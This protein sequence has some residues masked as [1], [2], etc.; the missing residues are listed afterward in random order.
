MNE[1][2]NDLS[3]L[4]YSIASTFTQDKTLIKDLYQQGVIGALNACK[5]YRSECNAKFSTYARM[6]IYGEIYRYI[7]CNKT[8]MI[9][10][11]IAR[12]YFNILKAYDILTQE[13][14]KEPSIKEISEY[15]NID[16]FIINNIIE[17]MRNPLSINYEYEDDNNLENYIKFN[18]NNNMELNELLDSL[19]EEERELIIHRYYEGYSQKETAEL[20]N[21]SQAGVSRCEAKSLEK[22][23]IRSLS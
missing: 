2:I 12:E 6:Y 4:I 10:K 16:E 18:D 8:V 21:M 11:D 7:N 23:R 19:S 13:L 14:N 20:M 5:N 15:L 17:L 1:D 3:G 9:N 22:M